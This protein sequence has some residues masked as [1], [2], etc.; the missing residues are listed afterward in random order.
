MMYERIVPE[1]KKTQLKRDVSTYRGEKLSLA[2]NPCQNEKYLIHHIRIFEFEGVILSLTK[3][4]IRNRC[5]FIPQMISC[6][7]LY[8]TLHAW[9]TY[10][11]YILYTCIPPH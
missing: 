7:V 1:K 11:N 6:D 9:S 10:R 8:T 3:W 5:M 2:V 4:V